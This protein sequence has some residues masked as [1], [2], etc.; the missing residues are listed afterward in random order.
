MHL[1][2]LVGITIICNLALH[3]ARLLTI[4]Q[5]F[6]LLILLL[7]SLTIEAVSFPPAS[8][9]F[10][11]IGDEQDI[12]D[13]VVTRLLQDSQGFIW[14]GTP[15]GLIRYDGYRFKRYPHI[16]DQQNSL[17][18]NFIVDMTITPDGKMWVISEPGG[19]AI[20]QP[21]TDDFQRLDLA[22]DSAGHKIEQYARTLTTDSVGTVWLGGRNGFMSMDSSGSDLAF[23][24]FDHDMASS[25]TQVRVLLSIDNS[26][27]IGAK[28]GLFLLDKLSKQVKKVTLP[29]STDNAVTQVLSLALDNNGNLWIGTANQGLYRLELLSGLSEKIPTAANKDNETAI[30]HLLFVDDSTLWLAR[31]DGVEAFDIS[32]K[33]WLNKVSSAAPSRYSLA[34]SDMRTMFKDSAGQIWLGGYGSGVKVYQSQS[35]ISVLNAGTGSPFQLEHDNISSI[36]ERKNG[37]IWLGSR[38]DGISVLDRRRGVIQHYPPSPGE[39]D[40][41]QQGWITTML[42]FGTDE[43]WVGVNEGQLYRFSTQQQIFQPVEADTGFWFANVRKLFVDNRQQLWLA[44]NDGAALWHETTQQFKRITTSDGRLLSDYINGF[45]DDGQHIWLATGSSGLLAIDPSTL[46]ATP[47]VLSPDSP[48]LPQSILGLL[49][50]EQKRL[51]LDT[52]QGLFNIID[53]TQYPLQLRSA[54]MLN[55]SLANDMGA[56]LLQDQQGRIWTQRYVYMPDSKQLYSLTPADGVYHGTNWYRSYTKTQDG[57]MLFGGSQGLLIVQPDKFKPWQ[58]VPRVQ[59]TAIQVDGMSKVPVNGELLLTSQNRGFSVEFAGL[60]LSAPE[61]I[62]YR[63]KLE[64]FDND[65]RYTD[66]KQRLATYTNLWPGKYQL[67]VE[68]TNRSLYW[69]PNTYQ[70]AVRVQP[71]YWQTLWFMLLLLSGLSLLIYAFIKYRTRLLRQQARQLEQQVASRTAELQAAQ[72]ALSEKE[73][74]AALGQ[75]VAGVAHEINTPLGISITASSLQHEATDKLQQQFASKQL[76]SAHLQQFLQQSTANLAILNSNLHRSA[77][78]V[79]TFKEIAVDESMS[80]PAAIQLSPWL[81][82]RAKL[83]GSLCSNITLNINCPSNLKLLLPAKALEAVL[84]HLIRNS[85]VHGFEATQSGVVNISADYNAGI[86]TLL[87]QDNGAGIAEEVQTTLFDPFVTTKRGS[88][89]KGLGLHLCFNLVTQVLAGSIALYTTSAA[90][91]AFKLVF[92]ATKLD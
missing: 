74:M 78:L 53:T 43:V 18:G 5:Q 31:F 15:S 50:D 51:W 8:G 63:Y 24:N 46:V 16:A 39:R 14:V 76:T 17:G 32:N 75:L 25:L 27:F 85:V 9:V 44:T 12:P 11:T 77:D 45:A 59:A 6:M 66:A 37:E 65:W 64:G 7:L 48:A 38:G 90:G 28:E 82:E 52:P 88:Q 10:Q 3:W 91:A 21:D 60:D 58:Y 92:P 86:C 83:L 79:Q 57:L 42:E 13:N 67:H 56:N 22:S 54:V 61:S 35:A 33:R 69:S 47:V 23:Y 84:L 34:H 19:V 20:Y 72:K 49:Y 1:F 73:K 68:A 29:F 41:L 2:V 4:T 89:C 70:L 80:V 55:Q 30:N 81:A 40:T 62:K 26:L 71:A 36:L 87:Y